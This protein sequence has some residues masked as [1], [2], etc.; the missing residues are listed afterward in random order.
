MHK[1]CW[2]LGRCVYFA[3]TT[4]CLDYNPPELDFLPLLDCVFFVVVVVRKWQGLPSEPQFPISTWRLNF[5]SCT[6]QFVPL[7]TCSYFTIAN[8]S[9]CFIRLVC[10]C[11]CQGIA[12]RGVV[13][14]SKRG[15]KIHFWTEF[16]GFSHVLRGLSQLFAFWAHPTDLVSQK[17][18]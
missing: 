4:T 18:P 16:R 13:Q 6:V 7:H 1:Q 3:Y 12:T 8:T 14:T 10:C 9:S 5:F 15:R 17:W 11:H 2:R